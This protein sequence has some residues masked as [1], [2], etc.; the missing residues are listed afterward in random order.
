MIEHKKGP[1]L[2]AEVQKSLFPYEKLIVK[3]LDIAGLLKLSPN[4]E[5]K[6]QPNPDLYIS[7]AIF[8]RQIVHQTSF[9]FP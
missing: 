2:A 5:V 4:P 8:S 9:H 7:P 1:A 6:A 3:G